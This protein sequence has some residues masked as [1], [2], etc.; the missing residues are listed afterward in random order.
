MGQPLFAL[1][2]QLAK[3]AT[4]SGSL[5]TV[6]LTGIWIACAASGAFCE[7]L[8]ITLIV[9]VYVPVL[10]PATT[11]AL[12]EIENGVPVTALGGTVNH[13]PPLVYAGVRNSVICW[14]LGALASAL[15]VVAVMVCALG[16]GPFSS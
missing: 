13:A 12:S 11:E 4:I 7:P 5:L 1:I 15:V 10:R 2:E 16:I 6:R 9:P 8:P 14:L 3:D